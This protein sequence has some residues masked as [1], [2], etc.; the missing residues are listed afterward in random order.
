[1]KTQFTISPEHRNELLKF[2]KKHPS[3]DAV[4]G[5]CAHIEQKYKLKPISAPREKVIGKSLDDLI[6]H[7][8]AQ[9]KLWRE[10][11][12]TLQFGQQ[13][14][15]ETT[16]KIF[17]CP[18][19]H[20]AIGNNMDAHPADRMYEHVSTCKKNEKLGDGVPVKSFLVSEDID[21]IK[22]HIKERRSS[23]KKVVY[24]SSNG[25]LFN[26]KEAVLDDFKKNQIKPMTFFEAV[27]NPRDF[28]LE[29]R[30]EKIIHDEV[31][32]EKIYAFLEELSKHADFET[33]VTRCQQQDE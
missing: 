24:T 25:K 3:A 9:G 10:K 4:E 6:T 32:E 30:L 12:I 33:Y 31:V 29:S 21:L 7:L 1:M 16:V 5:Y 27:Q 11:E 22:E 17:I 18:F 13:S 15:N 23:V 2:L 19:C 26:S 20:K 8:E 28:E 14:V